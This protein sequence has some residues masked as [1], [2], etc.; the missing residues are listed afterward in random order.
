[1]LKDPPRPACKGWRER[2][3]AGRGHRAGTSAAAA[4]PKI[5]PRAGSTVG[6]RGGEED[7][8]HKT[9]AQCS[10]FVQG[11]SG[12]MSATQSPVCRG[13][14]EMLGSPS[15]AM[16]IC[17]PCCRA[18]IRP[19][20]PAVTMFWAGNHPRQ[21]RESAWTRRPHA[22]IPPTIHRSIPGALPKALQ[23]ITHAKDV[24]HPDTF[25]GGRSSLVDAT[26]RL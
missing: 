25:L 18:S 26:A 6:A 9:N 16:Q 12:M 2:Q 10:S 24:P 17:R 7:T 13:Q 1:M 19:T 23:V 21:S 20:T 8:G 5:A 3:G 11:A 15:R 22:P 14:R 4:T